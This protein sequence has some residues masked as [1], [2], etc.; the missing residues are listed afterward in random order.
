M[1]IYVGIPCYGVAKSIKGVLERLLAVRSDLHL[2]LVNDGSKDNLDEVIKTI[3]ASH[4]LSFHYHKHEQNKGYGGTQKTIFKIFQ[5]LSKN[6]DDLL[7]L[8]HGDGETSEAEINNFIEGAKK[9]PFIDVFLGSKMLRPFREQWRR[10][11]AAYKIFFDYVLTI[12]QNKLYNFNLSTCTPGYRCYRRK[13]LD[14]IDF[15]GTGD[16]HTF[17]TESLIL[18]RF[19]NIKYKEIPIKYVIGHT[20][21]SANNLTAYAKDTIKLMIRYGYKWRT[22]SPHYLII[23]SDDY[24]Y[25]LSVNRGIAK[26]LESNIISSAT[27]MANADCFEDAVKKA[28][29]GKFL[30]KLGVHI[31]LT[32]GTPL[33]KNYKTIVNKKGEFLG[34]SA[35]ILK[36]IFKK[37]DYK[38]VLEEVELKIQKCQ[39]ASI[40]ISHIDTHQWSQLTKEVSRAIIN[41]AYKYN[42]S[43]IRN[44]KETSAL[45]FLP[46]ISIRSLFNSLVIEGLRRRHLK[47]VKNSNLQAPEHYYG[48]MLTGH[49][50]YKQTL[51]YILQTLG[52][53]TTELMCHLADRNFEDIKNRNY[54]AKGRF[55]ELEALSSPEI[56]KIIKDKNIHL[57][58]YKEFAEL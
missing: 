21:M 10:G 47:E 4:F 51:K 54:F 7:I 3:D 22:R 56:R 9:Q 40:P 25:S 55:E 57:V 5:S 20:G 33:G 44:I 53:G 50:S 39:N 19:F 23:N 24:G 15:S 41:S 2:I 29:E 18:F 49:L 32:E 6:K 14:K 38:E 26:A 30:E 1:E 17:D 45:R 12:I 13:G 35:L 8:L 28:K 37:I 42:V 58:S 46:G 11:R 16:R 43:C 31:N 27:I 52:P 36:S 34:I 48:V